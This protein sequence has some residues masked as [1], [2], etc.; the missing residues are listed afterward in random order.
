MAQGASGTMLFAGDPGVAPE[1]V[2][3]V[4]RV[5][6]VLGAMPAAEPPT[7]LVRRTLDRVAA[8]QA[9]PMHRAER[10]LIDAGRPHA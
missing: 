8:G 6:N 4:E 3:A 10:E 5:L 1:Q 9:P 2:A 7:D